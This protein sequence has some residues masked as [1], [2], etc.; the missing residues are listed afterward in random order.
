MGA[1]HNWL[2]GAIEEAVGGSGS[3]YEV[4]AW[5]VEMTGAGDPPYVIY[6]RTATVRE[7]LL[8]DALDDTPEIGLLRPVASFTVTVYADS[9]VEC[10]EIADAITLAIHRFTGSAHGETIQTALVLDAA[11]GDSGFLEGREQP[12]F[13]VELTVEITFEE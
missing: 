2:K 5:P 3:G 1:P 13:T 7:L 8:P 4:T 10:W 12:T 6:S 11:D 9:Y